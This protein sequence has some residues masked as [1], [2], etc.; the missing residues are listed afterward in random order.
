MGGPS[1]GLKSPTN[2]LSIWRITLHHYSKHGL[3]WPRLDEACLK[4][5]MYILVFG[6]SVYGYSKDLILMI[7]L[8]RDRQRSLVVKRTL[9]ILG[10]VSDTLN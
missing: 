3:L 4:S 2:T 10:L 8:C 7:L 9:K 6:S 1:K 5:M